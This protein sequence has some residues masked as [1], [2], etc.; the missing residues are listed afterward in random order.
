MGGTSTSVGR[1][2][3]SQSSPGA[4]AAR[5]LGR[6]ESHGSFPVSSWQQP[7]GRYSSRQGCKVPRDSLDFWRCPGDLL[8]QPI[9]LL[10]SEIIGGCFPAFPALVLPNNMDPLIPGLHQVA[11]VFLIKP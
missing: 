4:T 8:K 9:S 11:P 1:Q 10:Q 6:C 2:E 5:H 3:R 7:V